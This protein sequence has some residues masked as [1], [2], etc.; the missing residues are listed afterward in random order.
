MDEQGLVARTMGY[1]AGANPSSEPMDSTS[2]ESYLWIREVIPSG[3]S[4]LGSIRG[5]G[6]A[7]CEFYTVTQIL[8]GIWA[9]LAP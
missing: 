5:K 4:R 1:Q 2:T 7:G 8:L 3:P 6:S 9:A